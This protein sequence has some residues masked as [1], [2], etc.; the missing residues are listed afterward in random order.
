MTRL[1]D[2]NAIAS[3]RLASITNLLEEEMTVYIFAD[4]QLHA[5]KS[6]RNI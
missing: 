4:P 1:W 6:N 3:V 5:V 2:R